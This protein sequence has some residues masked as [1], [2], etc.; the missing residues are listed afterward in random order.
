[1]GSVM[2]EWAMA[3]VTMVRLPVRSAAGSEEDRLE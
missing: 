1:L 3:S 2:I